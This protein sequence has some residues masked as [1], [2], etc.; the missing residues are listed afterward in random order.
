MSDW[1]RSPWI[2]SGGQ[3]VAK[4][5]ALDEATDGAAIEKASS[6]AFELGRSEH[7]ANRDVCDLAAPALSV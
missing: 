2:K 3:S 1:L 5:S 4:D 7:C 6:A